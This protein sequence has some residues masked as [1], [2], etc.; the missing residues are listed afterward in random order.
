LE[1]ATHHPHNVAREAFVEVGGMLQNAPAPRFSRTV[2]AVP[3][4][5][6]AHAGADTNAIIADWGIDPEL[7]ARARQAGGLG[8]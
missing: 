7:V 3:K 8:N 2:N 4:A 6:P 5:P 1:E